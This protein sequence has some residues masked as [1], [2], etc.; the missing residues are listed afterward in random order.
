MSKFL[1]PLI[2]GII[3]LLASAHSKA[4]AWANPSDEGQVEYWT[5]KY[6]TCEE[7][8]ND[9]IHNCMGLMEKAVS[10]QTSLQGQLATANS[11]YH[12]YKQQ[13]EDSVEWYNHPGFVICCTALVTM[14]LTIATPKV[15]KNLL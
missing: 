11:E 14:V 13:Y 15:Y 6:A 9:A 10:V 7:N 1:A 3:F 2:L 5:P 4:Q 12:F 8:L